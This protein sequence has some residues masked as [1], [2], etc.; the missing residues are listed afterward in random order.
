M[1]ATNDNPGSFLGRIS[2]RRN[3]VIAMDAPD[4]DLEDLE[5][6]QKHVGDRFAELHAPSD[7]PSSAHALLSISWLRRVLDVFLCC[8]AEFKAIVIM[9][10]DP[11][12]IAKPPLDRLIPELLERSVKALD[13]CNAVTTGIDALRHCQKFAEIA[14]SALEQRPIGDGQVRRARKALNSLMIA[15][16]FDEKESSNSRTTDR[17]WSF[18]RRGG[19]AASKY[20]PGGHIRSLTGQVAKNWSAAKQIQ[21]MTYNLVAPRGADASS[22]ASPV[23]VM[24]TVIV[25][26]MWALV[27]AIP[28]QD[29]T[30]LAAHFPVPKQ[31]GWAQSLIGLQEKIGEEWKKKEKKG[32]SGLLEELQKME[33][34]A[35]NLSEFAESFQF[36]GEAEKVEEVATQVTEL[37]VTCQRMEEGLIPLQLQI[38]EMFHRIV[39]SRTEFLEVL[40]QAG[41]A[42]APVA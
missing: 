32:T 23:Y 20:Q 25:F 1:P 30:G 3:Q 39:R 4:S 13:L 15:M 8:E 21:A 19:G 40:D 41:K 12:Q 27:A 16:T 28:C 6:F 29:R 37:A 34:L 24:S 2:I 9:G 38:R 18:G 36:P 33:K 35:Q 7:E 22:L 14:V 31:L 42:S 5:L 26:V 10:R 17:A 11:S